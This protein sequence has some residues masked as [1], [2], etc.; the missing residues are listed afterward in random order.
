L[1]QTLF[2]LLV[3]SLSALA[4]LCI[5][6]LIRALIEPHL[7]DTDSESLPAS[8][9]DRISS[10]TPS[11]KICFFSDLHAALCFIPDEKLLDA[12]F[13]SPSDAIVFGG[14]VCNKGKAAGAG[15]QSLSRIAA[16][17]EALGIPCYA[18]RGNHDLGISRAQYLASGFTLLENENVSLHSSSG[19]EYLL[20]GLNDSGKKNRIWP[21][22][23]IANPEEYPVERRILLVHNPEYLNAVRNRDYRYMLSAIFTAARFI[24]RSIWNTGC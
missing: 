2:I 8:D 23:R 10:K 11:L 5:G 17:A 22:I 16:R 3:L 13:S 12:I 24:L 9:G 21:G 6:L 7:L 1:N 19:Q 20:I 18:I 15:L 4:A 14:D